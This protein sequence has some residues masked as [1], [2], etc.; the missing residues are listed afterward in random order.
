MHTF[1]IRNSRVVTR[2]CGM[3]EQIDNTYC[4]YLVFSIKK[5]K[6]AE[7]AVTGDSWNS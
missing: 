3:I 4:H 7:E 5:L 6:E 2:T 1:F